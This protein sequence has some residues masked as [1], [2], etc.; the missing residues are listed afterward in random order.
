M[1]LTK[2]SYS[3]ITGASVNVKD[4]GA[5]GDGS[6]DDTAAIQAAINYASSIGATL[7]FPTGVFK[8]LS[9]LIFKNNVS[10]QG[11]G[12]SASGLIGTVISYAGTS[13]AIQINNPINSS[14]SAYINIRNIYV[15]CTT[16]TS[17]K[18][19]IADVGSTYLNLENVRVYGNDY[20]V[21]LDQSEVVSIRNCNIG[22]TTAGTA[23]LWLVNNAAHTIGASAFFTNRITVDGC[24]FD[25]GST[26]QCIADDGGV[27]H[28][29]TN[30]NFNG[31]GTGIRCT[32]VQGLLISGNEFEAATNNSISF[33]T[34]T[35]ASATGNYCTTVTVN[36]NYFSSST[37]N[38]VVIFQSSSVQKYIGCSNNFNNAN[39]AGAPYS[40]VA[41][42]VFDF[43]GVGNYQTGIGSQV[44]G[45]TVSPLTSYTPTFASSNADASI[46]NG[47]ISGNYV[48][49]GANITVT[50]NFAVGSTTTK[51]TGQWWF[52]LPFACAGAIINVGSFIGFS[53]GTTFRAGASDVNGGLNYAR[54]WENAVGVLGGASYA[55][56]NGDFV[57]VTITYPVSQ[58]L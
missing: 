21:I 31:G 2:V 19:A 25:A 45:N 15:F 26:G 23:G 22:V 36:S 43:Y 10:Y 42:G 33:N 58:D 17:G 55:W 18:A 30:N 12:L 14:T 50:I 52:G 35:L 56:A 46:G 16:K 1:A 48:R 38:P 20:G 4:Y 32:N 49:T 53:A 29:F 47:T 40:G 44:V 37:V 11:A 6:T 34:T 7:I 54:I 8:C 39:V 13:D 28:T 24:Q 9:T 3:M 27:S 57:Y 41:A 51:G 5:V